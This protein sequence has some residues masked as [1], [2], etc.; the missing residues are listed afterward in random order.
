MA[1]RNVELQLQALELIQQKYG[2]TPDL[3]IP[4]RATE[5]SAPPEDIKN[6]IGKSSELEREILE[7]VSRQ[8][9]IEDEPAEF[10]AEE[11]FLAN[12]KVNL[13]EALKKTIGT[14]AAAFRL[15][16]LSASML[17]VYRR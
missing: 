13:E 9:P 14:V 6:H 4:Q 10:E 1:Q 7:E 3:F 17:Y 12:E 16:A 2:R 8:F 5:E 11:T 15:Y